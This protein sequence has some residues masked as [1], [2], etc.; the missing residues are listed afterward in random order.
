MKIGFF[1]SGLG[2]LTILKAVVKELPQYDYVYYGD[3]LHL[4]YGD[5]TEEEIFTLTKTGIEYLFEKGCVLVIVACN[6]AS[7]ET[8]RKLQDSWLLE[9]YPDRKVLGVIV[10]TL[11]RVLESNLSNVALLATKRTV[12]SDK[13]NVELQ[14]RS[15]QTVTLTQIAAPELVPFIE[16]NERKAATQAAIARIEFVAGES[17]GVILGC[18]HYTQIKDQ[19]RSHFGNTK[20][21][22][23]QDEIIPQKIFSYLK[24]HSEVESQLTQAGERSV[25]L[26]QHRPDYDLI[27][28]QFLGGAFLAEE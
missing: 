19:L 3:T 28:G 18:T 4:P 10:P 25:H 23:S 17:E 20:T 11:E 15:G 27:M 22:F 5:K 12:E 13:Y 14:N 26:T 1:D 7:A 24:N 8:L 21:I 2:G 6:T 9:T 16:L